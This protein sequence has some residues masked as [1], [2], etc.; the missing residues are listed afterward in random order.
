MQACRIVGCGMAGEWCCGFVGLG[1]GI[2]R[3][4]VG[5]GN[6]NEASSYHSRQIGLP[7][8]FANGLLFTY[9]SI[10]FIILRW[11]DILLECCEVP[12]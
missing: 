3:V 1:D 6:G 5:D 12:I 2:C 8:L 10:S 11:T 7:D 9:Y 4:G